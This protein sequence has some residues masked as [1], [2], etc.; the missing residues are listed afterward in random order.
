[1]EE[2][3]LCLK[4]VLQFFNQHVNEGLVI[5]LDDD[6]KEETRELADQCLTR[7]GYRKVRT[8]IGDVI[9]GREKYLRETDF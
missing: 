4:P 7:V 6:D 1:M 9:F 8:Q 2:W 3:I 5:D